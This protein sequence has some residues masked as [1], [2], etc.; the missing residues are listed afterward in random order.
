MINMKR[1]LI[2]GAIVALALLCTSCDDKP[3]PAEQLPAAVQAYVEQ[4]YPG[5]RIL[6]AEKDY[7][8]FKTTYKVKLDS[9]LELSFNK[10]GLLTDIDD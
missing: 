3:I 8:L 7:D 1:T 4:N 2:P 5:N 9:G 6:I 10:N